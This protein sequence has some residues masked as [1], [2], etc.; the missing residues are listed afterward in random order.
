[1]SIYDKFVDDRRNMDKEIGN[2]LLFDEMIKI[3]NTMGKANDIDSLEID[4]ITID[5]KNYFM[6]LEKKGE[7][8]KT[9]C[10]TLWNVSLNLF[11]KCSDNRN[12]MFE[13]RIH[14]VDVGDDRY[15]WIENYHSVSLDYDLL[16]NRSLLFYYS[17][18]PSSVYGAGFSLFENL[19]LNDFI[20]R[21][22]KPRYKENGNYMGYI[23]LNN[24]LS[25]MENDKNRI[26]ELNDE[27]SSKYVRRF[28]HLNKD[29]ITRCQEFG[30]TDFNNISEEDV[31]TV[32][33][34]LNLMKNECVNYKNH[35]TAI[36]NAKRR[37]EYNLH[38]FELLENN[39]FTRSE[40]QFLGEIFADEVK[41]K[42]EELEEEKKHVK[43]KEMIK[44]L[45][46]EE[47]E[48]LKDQLK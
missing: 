45:N 33:D 3:I 27:G 36:A 29:V 10:E 48:I 18:V 17:F 28:Y 6:A 32:I 39:L 2:L 34:K 25:D 1:M 26:I 11:I 22:E 30:D 12:L 35:F 14:S 41:L 46:S 47:L 8:K 4:N 31:D 44:N 38:I 19:R 20:D 40:L 16:D 43:V 5:D 42:K 21:L 37:L 23:S 15:T 7:V 13:V 9:Y 24:L